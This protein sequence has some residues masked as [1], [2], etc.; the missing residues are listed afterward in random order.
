MAEQ[1]AGKGGA[2]ESNIKETVESILIAFILAFIFRAFVVE[3]FVIPTGSMAP[4]LYG[5]HMRFRCPDCGTTF[6]V[7]YSAPRPRHAE[8]TDIPSVAARQD[9]Y[10]CPNCGYRFPAGEAQRVR[11]GDR[12]LVLKYLYLFERPR[13]GDTVVFKSPYE[14]DHNPDDPDYAVNYIKR[15]VGIGPET[16]VLLDGDVY[17]APLGS[18]DPRELKIWRKPEHVQNVLWRSVYDND[19]IPHLQSYQRSAEPWK[20]PWEAAGGSGWD[21]GAEGRSRVFNFSGSSAGTIRFNSEA[22]RDTHALTDYLVYDEREHNGA[23][24]PQ[25][26]S[27]LKLGCTY[28]RR[29][30]QGPLRL[31]LTKLRDCF[32]AQITP[33]KVTLLRSTLNAPG[34]FDAATEH[35]VGEQTIAELNGSRPARV[36]LTNVDYRVTVWI[37]GSAAITFDY[38][39]DV[40]GLWARAVDPAADPDPFAKPLVRIT[41]GD[42]QCVIEHLQLARDIYYLNSRPDMLFW[43]SPRKPAD[44]KAGEYF[45]LGD[46]S[47][48]SGDARFWNDPIRLPKEG[49][50]FVESGRVPEQFML[51]KAFFVYW[52][53]G[54]SVPSTGINIV[55]DFGDMRFIH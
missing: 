11:F 21:L 6:D 22:N 7:G 16:I 34:S 23:W 13:R 42:Q 51:G 39:P 32:T 14:D 54:Y 47:F 52:P 12:I 18:R 26:V 3:A 4:T 44:L 33:G 55:P 15:L 35:V 29:S 50:P 24:R 8:E 46:N 40:V 31:Q 10:H 43:G 48:I 1:S 30:G 28:T 17:T 53:A 49:M 37:N 41:A 2:S 20:Q 27:D 5:A 38:E 36:E 9:D 19:F 25:P 45:V